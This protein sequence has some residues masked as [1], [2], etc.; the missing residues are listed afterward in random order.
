MTTT[1]AVLAHF[2]GLSHSEAA[3]FLDV[4]IHTIK[5][6]GVGKRN[7]PPGAIEQLADL[8]QTIM[9]TAAN[10]LTEIDRL[11]TVH[12]KPEAIDLG[13]AVD[14]IEAQDLGLPFAS[15][16]QAVIGQIVA[17]GMKKGY[18]FNVVPRG[19]TTASAAAADVHDQHR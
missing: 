7:C 10:A 9:A 11:A 12:S 19:T 2:C 8:S 16:H 3:E 17:D 15:T 1:F 4:S 5:K 18:R 13:V 6:W 14:D